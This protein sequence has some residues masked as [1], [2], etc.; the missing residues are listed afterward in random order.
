MWKLVALLRFV[1]YNKMSTYRI[2]EMDPSGLRA[3]PF[4]PQGVVLLMNSPADVWA[5]ILSL[6]EADMTATTINT[7][8]DDATAVALEDDR[9]VLY[10]PT[11]SSGTSSPPAMSPKSRPLRDLFSCDMEVT[12]L[13]EGE[14]DQYQQEPEKTTSSPAP[15]STP[16]SA[17]WWAP[18]TSLPTPPPGRWPTTRAR[19]TTPCSSTG[20][21]AWAR[22]TCCTP[23][24][25][26]STRTT[27]STRWFT[28]RGTPSPMS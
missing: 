5:K 11:A 10:S 1:W 18:P 19:A 3:L 26:P 12:V 28:S 14:L 24:L 16:S 21:P 7:W 20:S 9:F 2:G 23:S 15:R 4:L 8:F 25:T 27:R 13:T 22:P 17:S 6:M